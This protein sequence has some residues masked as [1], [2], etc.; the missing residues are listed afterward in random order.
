MELRPRLREHAD[1]PRWRGVQA[2][3][4]GQRCG[5]PPFSASTSP[6]SLHLSGLQGLGF[7]RNRNL[8]GPLEAKLSALMRT[9][10]CY[11]LLLCSGATHLAQNNPA[12][13]AAGTGPPAP[14]GP[15]TSNSPKLLWGS[16]QVSEVS[17]TPAAGDT[18][19]SSRPRAQSSG[20]PWHAVHTEPNA[21]E[22]AA[23]AGKRGTSELTLQISIFT[24]KK[25][26]VF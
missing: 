21:A 7:P 22:A 4:H 24:W 26:P 14:R 20:A 19:L 9:P 5:V 3:P 13:R 17:S 10:T 12:S 11:T 23:H 2:V 25:N 6:S 16:H 8:A 15:P 18:T 1:M